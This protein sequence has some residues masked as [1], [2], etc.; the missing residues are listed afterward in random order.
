MY[1]YT[2]VGAEV[3]CRTADGDWTKGKV[4]ARLY[5]DSTMPPGMVAPYQV[6]LE[7]NGSLI[8]APADE[9]TLVRKA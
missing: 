9:D 1:T 3:E 8:Y 4:V 5:R 6:K 2:H 7:S